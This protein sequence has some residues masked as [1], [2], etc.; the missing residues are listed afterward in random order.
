MLKQAVG[1]SVVYD[2]NDPRLKNKVEIHCNV[3]DKTGIVRHKSV[4]VTEAEKWVIESIAMRLFIDHKKVV[5]KDKTDKG[6][7]RLT[8]CVNEGNY[9]D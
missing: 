2:E 1:I 8:G 7:V 9:H 3:V 5:K 6:K 4:K